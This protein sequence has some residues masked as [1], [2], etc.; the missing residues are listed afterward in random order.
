M[1]GHTHTLIDSDPSK[2]AAP[3][4]LS[5]WTS[6]LVRTGMTVAELNK[7]W[8]VIKW[9]CLDE[10]DAGICDGLTYQQVRAGPWGGWVDA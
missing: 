9:R 6:T 4:Q 8:E 1:G 10:I 3:D 2:P 5:I 7:S